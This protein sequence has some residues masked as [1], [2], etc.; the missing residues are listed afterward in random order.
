VQ[1]LTPQDA[2]KRER[3]RKEEEELAVAM[4]VSKSE[5]EAAEA[6]LAEPISLEDAEAITAAQV[7]WIGG[8]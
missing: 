6:V 3:L 4:A 1:T 8:N 2:K 5:A 7:W